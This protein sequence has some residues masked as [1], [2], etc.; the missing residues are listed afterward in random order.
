MASL[1]EIKNAGFFRDAAEMKPF[2]MNNPYFRQYILGKS[3]MGYILFS[4]SSKLS[5]DLTGDHANYNLSW[6]NPTTG[7][8][9]QSK[10]RVT[11]DVVSSVSAPFEGA[12]VARLSKK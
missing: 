1:P 4:S 6:I 7:E 9:V 8:I 3:G 11:G 12:A 10:I 5:I 2:A